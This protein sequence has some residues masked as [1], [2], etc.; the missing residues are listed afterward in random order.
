MKIL[1]IINT[2]LV[3]L[4]TN[5]GIAQWMTALVAL[6][7]LLYARKEFILKRRPFIDIDIL[8]AKNPN[9]TIGGWFFY[10]NIEN[11]GTYPG[12]A[13]IRKTVMRVGDEVYPSDVKQSF[14]VSPGE[15]KKSALIGS[16]NNLGINKI[17]GH[18]YRR[19]RVEIEIIVES[20]EINEKKMKYLT[21]V[22]YGVD[23]SGAQP[24]LTLV[25]EKYS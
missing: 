18:E 13:K 25:K 22:V 5:Q 16:I 6:G 24:I 7:A 12:Q 2:F 3:W 19:N 11:K 4:N 17:I 21:R 1:E 9:A 20:A 15:S 8:I 10:A 14:L 23:V